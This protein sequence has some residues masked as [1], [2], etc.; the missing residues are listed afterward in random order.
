MKTFLASLAVA[1]TAAI[2]AAA[3]TSHDAAQV[4]IQR[5]A[6][7]VDVAALSNAEVATLLNV[8]N[9]GDSRSDV[10]AKIESLVRAYQ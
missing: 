1:A 10:S 3:V 8:I 5:Y 4:K 7:N 6:P 2:P 9:S